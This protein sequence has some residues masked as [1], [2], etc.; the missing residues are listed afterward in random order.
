MKGEDKAIVQTLL[1][2]FTDE[3]AADDVSRL[4]DLIEEKDG[5]KHWEYVYRQHIDLLLEDL[6]NATG[7]PVT[8]EEWKIGRGLD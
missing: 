3:E 5:A 2:T 6:G 1:N 7:T 4:L 8:Y